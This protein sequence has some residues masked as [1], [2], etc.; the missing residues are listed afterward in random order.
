MFFKCVKHNIFFVGI[1]AYIVDLM[2]EYL[3]LYLFCMLSMSNSIYCK[4]KIDR[5]DCMCSIWTSD[6]S[7][8]HTKQHFYK[9]D[10]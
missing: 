3:S 4:Y 7:Q 9:V 1:Y 6:K 5:S 2:L 10:L 8:K